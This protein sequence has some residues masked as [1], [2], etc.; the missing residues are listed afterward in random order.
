MFPL[1]IGLGAVAD[2]LVAAL[3]NDEWQGVAIY[4]SILS[5]LSVAR[6]VGW[7][8]FSFLQAQH[9]TRACMAVEVGKLASILGGIAALSA[10]GP[11][12]AAGGVGLGFALH[13]L[14]SMALLHRTDGVS[15]RAMLRAMSGPLL[16]CV[17]MVGAVLAVRHGLC[18]AVCHPIL[19]LVVEVMAG[20]LVYLVSCFIVARGVTG[21]FL[22]LMRRS[23]RG[24][25]SGTVEG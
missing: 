18:L 5:A 19:G 7:I 16:A 3:F 12:W 2:T 15:M 10:F 4:L 22:G 11:Y 8:I 23:F 6:P 20:A 14:A 9:R 1:A 25:V 24:R 17:P 13:A 21:D